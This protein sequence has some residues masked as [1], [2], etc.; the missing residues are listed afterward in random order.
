MSTQ[1]N[2]IPAVIYARYSSSG[3]REESIE[4][5]LREC[6]AY[7]KHNGF[8]VVGEYID[9]ALTGR[10]DKRPDF[11]RMLR[12]NFMYNFHKEEISYM[13][14][15]EEQFSQRFAPFINETNVI[16]IMDELSDAQRDIEQ[17]VN[18]Q[19]VFF[20]FALKMIMLLK[21]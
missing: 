11:Q 18:A 13:T 16:G 12:E 8:T 7:A 19:M 15:E 5:Q 14:K 21:R 1:N 2:Q 4:G 9:K 6:H 3:Q 20:D 17:N 10:T